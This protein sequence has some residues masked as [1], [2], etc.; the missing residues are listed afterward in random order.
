MTRKLLF[1]CS[2]NR[3]R[4][5]TAEAVCQGVEGIEAISAGTNN[6]AE[7]PLTGDLIEW[8]DVVF[9]MERH[10]RNRITKKF[11]EQLKGKQLLVLGIPDDY[12]YMQPELMN[13]LKVRLHRWI[14]P[15]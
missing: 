5:P 3:L 1:V 7:Q 14:G 11:R 6:D 4:S 8:A 9:V 2:Q 13:L 15:C 12:E 10:H